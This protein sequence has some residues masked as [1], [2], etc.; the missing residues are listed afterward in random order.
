M[1][2]VEI[3]G[4]VVGL[5]CLAGFGLLAW[6]LGGGDLQ[7]AA[8]VA[9]A[10]SLAVDGVLAR[11]A[12]ARGRIDLQGPE[13]V[14]AQEPSMWT[15]SVGDCRRP[16]SLRFLLVGASQDVLAVDA[17]AGRLVV[18]PLPRGSIPFLVADLKARGPLGLVGAGRRLVITF[19]HP[20]PVVPV[21]RPVEVRWPT[22][23]ARAFGTHEGAPVGDDLFRTIRPYVRGDDRRRVHWKA[24]A[25]HRELM[26]RESDG[27][28]VVRVRIV[29][30][31]GPPGPGAELAAGAAL[32]VVEEALRRH[33]TVDLVTLD[34]AGQVPV[35]ASLGRTFGPPPQVAPPPLVALPTLDAPVRTRTEAGR[36]LATAAYGTPQVGDGDHDV[37][38]RVDQQGVHWS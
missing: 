28:G 22:V 11:R 8:A 30:D 17:R 33:W 24:T 31:L 13:V 19:V 29:V 10:V 26:V 20:I 16:V 3:T 32:H 27:L 21:V 36:R 38:C 35:L 15:A 14:E 5:A 37:T 1:V 9:I 7:L 25:H 12:V 4:A 6:F 34:A 18:P 23:R 2:H